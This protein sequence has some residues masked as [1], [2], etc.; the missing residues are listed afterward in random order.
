[1]H[2]LFESR[3]TQATQMTTLALSH[4]GKSGLGLCNSCLVQNWHHKRV[5]TSSSSSVRVECHDQL[6]P[7]Q[8]RAATTESHIPECYGNVTQRL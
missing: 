5:T 1:M 6:A 2:R 3:N 8:R 4:K 7:W